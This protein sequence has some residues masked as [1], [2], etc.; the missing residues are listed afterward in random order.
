MIRDRA[1]DPCDVGCVPFDEDC[2]GVAAPVPCA[3]DNTQRVHDARQRHT[4]R[5]IVPRFVQLGQDE[6]KTA[7]ISDVQ[8]LQF[9]LAKQ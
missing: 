1:I 4:V 5:C 8:D 7:C 6:R 2:C 3:F 9:A